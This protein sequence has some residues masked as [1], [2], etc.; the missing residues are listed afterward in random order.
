MTIKENYFTNLIANFFTLPLTKN[1]SD[2][3]YFITLLIYFSDKFT[4]YLY[5]QQFNIL[6]VI[7]AVA[8]IDNYW[9]DNN[10]F[11]IFF[12]FFLYNLVLILIFINSI[13][14]R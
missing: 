8:D 13:Q 9:V 11:T 6:S 12:S 2:L 10:Y 3:I 14:Y 5:Y 4:Q 1:E 7:V